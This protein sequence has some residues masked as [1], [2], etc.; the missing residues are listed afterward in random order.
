MYR[1]K[2]SVFIGDVCRYLI[3]YTPSR[4]SQRRPDDEPLLWV[5]VKNLEAMPLRA[6]YLAGPYIVYVDVRSGDY[7]QDVAAFSTA[8]QPIY[9]PQLKAAQSFYAPIYMNKVKDTYSWTVD[10]ISQILFSTNAEVQFEILIGRTKADL[11]N[12]NVTG[13]L[14]ANILDGLQ[15]IRLDTLD[16]WNSPSPLPDK[17]LHVVILSHGLHSNVS[18]DMLFLKEKIDE[19]A[20][21]TG[22]NLIV[23][24]YF[25][26]VCKTEK[27]IKFLGRRLGDY[28]MKD[29]MPSLAEPVSASLNKGKSRKVKISF[30]GH[31]LGGLVQTFALA[32]IQNID[33][34]F[35]NIYEP[36]NFIC[37]ACPFLG[38]SNENPG[39]VKVALDLGFVGKTGRDLG[40]TWKPSSPGKDR[41]PLLQILPSGPTHVVLE[42]FK[43]L[44]LYA[45][46]VNDGIVPL[47]T[48]AILYLDWRAISEASQEE[49]SSKKTS[50]SQLKVSSEKPDSYNNKQV[51]V[52]GSR[53]NSYFEDIDEHTADITDSRI[54]EFGEAE[55]L[56]SF[57]GPVLP[58]EVLESSPLGTTKVL[59]TP[60]TESINNPK[61]RSDNKQFSADIFGLIGAPLQSFVSSLAPHVGVKKPSKIYYRSQTLNEEDNDNQDTGSGSSKL[62]GIPKKTSML[63][64]GVSVIIPPLP[65]RSFIDDPSS[66][67]KTIFHDRV[68][69][70]SELPPRQYVR[71]GSIVFSNLVKRRSSSSSTSTMSS[72][73]DDTSPMSPSAA[74]KEKS[75]VEE[76]IAREWHRNLKWRKV[77]VKLEPDAHNNII[78]RRRFANAYG[79]PVIDHLVNN[80]FSTT[81]IG[82]PLPTY[83]PIDILRKSFEGF[84]EKNFR[85]SEDLTNFQ[86]EANSSDGN[87]AIEPNELREEE[88]KITNQYSS[89]TKGWQSH[90]TMTENDSDDEGIVHSM[91]GIIDRFRDFGLNYHDSKKP[92]ETIEPLEQETLEERINRMI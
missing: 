64:S 63:E 3:R 76:K 38:I 44:T 15:V 23:R 91:E 77:L 37:L 66:R 33:P 48:S 61:I 83:S 31:S 69:D 71:S 49:G 30:I 51:D 55:G 45:N 35:F 27:G 8:E 19:K 29:L 6:A 24:G 28:I 88:A 32:H 50:V 70:D 21:Q 9:E 92:D 42:K 12:H 34:Q 54:E 67:P 1:N 89:K 79:W 82:R 65:S 86:Y 87:I 20:K 7:N 40:M 26:N 46:A 74:L 78:V 85:N 62:T 39:Y 84:G 18:A 90:L 53:N 36:E 72:S 4:D 60:S 43:R 57:E 56:E 16:L 25:E 14:N 2:A 11:H 17:P 80:H 73:T 41:K 10:I 75:K 52:F 22:E 5:K 81:E 47:R 59:E 13:S 58:K 68:Y